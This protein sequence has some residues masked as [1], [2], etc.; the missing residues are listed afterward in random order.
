ME[1]KQ[2]NAHMKYILLIAI[3]F[4]LTVFRLQAQV[5]NDTST[6]SI[7]DTAYQF[8]YLFEKAYAEIKQMLDA[9]KPIR[10]KRAIFLIENA[11]NEGRLSEQWYNAT[12]DSI[13][14]QCKAMIAAKGLTGKPTAG[15]WAIFGYMTQPVPYNNN[16][17][18]SY[19]INNLTSDNAVSQQVY[20]LLKY[21]QGTCHSLPLLYLLLAQELQAEAYLVL[22]PMHLFIKHKDQY[23]EWW[24][25]ELTGGGYSR[26]S[27]IIE[28]FKISDKQIESGY[29]MK[30]LGKKEIL[31][32][33]LEDL[34]NYYEEKTK[35]V[36][37]DSFCA[38]V[39][40]LGL[41]FLPCSQHLLSKVNMVKYK[42]DKDM[43]KVGLNNYFKISP[44]P[45]LVAQ[46]KNWQDLQKKV[47]ATGYKPVSQE[48]YKAMVEQAFKTKTK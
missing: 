40:E 10:L 3:M 11:Y 36:Y 5:K 18:Y 23:G 45:N 48:W 9:K 33:L 28:S 41:K 12:I 1:F 19:D 17:P 15:N 31:A 7:P 43:E 25:L 26:T 46:Y 13:K 14:S 16:Q 21:R 44:Y 39:T 32:Y 27:F 30:M 34:Q 6:V 47:A 42:L 29:Y 22:A 8:K 37:W 2:H 20:Y 35:G 38:K 4:S 24:N